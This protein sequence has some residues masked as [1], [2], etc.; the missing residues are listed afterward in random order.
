MKRKQ[1]KEE[2]LHNVINVIF[3]NI[4]KNNISIKRKQNKYDNKK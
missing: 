2:T 3:R 1:E 4:Q